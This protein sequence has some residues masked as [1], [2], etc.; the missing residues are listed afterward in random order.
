MILLNL[1]NHP[2]AN[3]SEKQLNAAKLYGKV[4]DMAFPAIDPEDSE[5]NIEKLADIYLKEIEGLSVNN[6]ITVHIMGEL[7][8]CFALI[9]KL[10]S[11]NIKCIAS[12]SKRVVTELENGRKEVEFNFVRFREY[13]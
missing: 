10:N 13:L 2:S 6:T 9:K 8:F 12:T 11:K 7:T 1:S 5:N 3:W 4:K